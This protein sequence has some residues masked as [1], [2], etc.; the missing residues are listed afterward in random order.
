MSRLTEGREGHNEHTDEKRLSKALSYDTHP[1]II[2]FS[3]IAIN[4]CHDSTTVRAE[5]PQSGR[6]ILDALVT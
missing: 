1:A 4:M 3:V 2:D 6:L 5:P